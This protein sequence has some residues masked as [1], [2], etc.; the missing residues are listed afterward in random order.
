MGEIKSD[1]GQCCC[2]KNARHKMIAR[3]EGKRQMSNAVGSHAT[4]TTSLQECLVRNENLPSKF[5]RPIILVSMLACFYSC[6]FC[7]EL[8]LDMLIDDET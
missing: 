1:V 4:L 2:S 6:L 5:H 7:L 8:S 3:F